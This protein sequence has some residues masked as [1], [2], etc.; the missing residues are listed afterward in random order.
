MKIMMNNGIF[1]EFIPFDSRYFSEDGELKSNYDALT[2]SEV[3]E[4]VDYALVISTNAGLWRYLIGDLV[5]FVDVRDSRLIISGRIKQFL[6]LCGEHLSLDNINQALKKVSDVNPSFEPEFTIFVDKEAQLHHWYFEQSNDQIDPERLLSKIDQELCKLN[7][8]Y[9]SARKYSLANPKITLLPKGIIYEYMNSLAK[10]GA[11]N[12]MPRV[13]NESQ[14]E[15]WH[16]FLKKA[17]LI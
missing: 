3:K 16:A 8:D 9:K 17:G 7:D 5:R 10:L 11:Q 13:L 6:S 2:I 15:N 4:G 12:K 1:F 14:A